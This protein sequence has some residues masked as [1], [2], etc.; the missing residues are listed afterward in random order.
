MNIQIEMEEKMMI[1]A[2]ADRKGES[3]PDEPIALDIPNIPQKNM[4]IPTA[5]P[6]PN[7]VPFFPILKEKG[8]AISTMIRLDN[9]K[10]YL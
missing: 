7:N 10:E 8:I 5:I 6:M 3:I 2:K 4:E 1:G 9:G